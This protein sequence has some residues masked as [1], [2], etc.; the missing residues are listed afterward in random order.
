MKW[1]NNKCTRLNAQSVNKQMF[2]KPKRNEDQEVVIFGILMCKGKKKKRKHCNND[3]L[4]A[5]KKKE[6]VGPF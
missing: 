6:N 2:A 4:M 1:E 3:K 5:Y